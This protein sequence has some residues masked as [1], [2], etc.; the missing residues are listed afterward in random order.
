[1]VSF[2]NDRRR[3][4]MLKREE[5][6]IMSSIYVGRVV[7]FILDQDVLKECFST[8]SSVKLSQLCNCY[9]QNQVS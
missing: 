4:E 7:M 3:D 8:E 5:K 9:E 6:E 2:N 1:M